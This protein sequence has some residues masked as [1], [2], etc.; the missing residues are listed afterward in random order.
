MQQFFTKLITHS[1]AS[2]VHNQGRVTYQLNDSDEWGLL[3]GTKLATHDLFRSPDVIHSIH[4][5]FHGG[6]DCWQV[7]RE[8]WSKF[9]IHPREDHYGS[10]SEMMATFERLS[11]Q[12]LQEV[13]LCEMGAGIS[14]VSAQGVRGG[15]LAD[16]GNPWELEEGAIYRT[17]RSGK[18]A[19]IRD[20][21]AVLVGPGPT[22]RMELKPVEYPD[23]FPESFDPGLIMEMLI[24][25][26]GRGQIRLLEE[27]PKEVMGPTSLSAPSSDGEAGEPQDM[28]IMEQ[29]SG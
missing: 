22:R 12:R 14:H 29:P 1:F 21:R 15:K 2:G 20:Y 18:G 11:G 3:G 23:D 16:L 28:H 24:R 19:T 27:I 13:T 8:H 6:R 26:G 17:V 5:N 9:T 10:L 4:L 25:G 7:E